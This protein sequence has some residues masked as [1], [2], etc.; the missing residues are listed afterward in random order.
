MEDATIKATGVGSWK[1][2]RSVLYKI[3]GRH[4]VGSLSGQGCERAITA[5]KEIQDILVS[6]VNKMGTEATSPT[7]LKGSVK[8]STKAKVQ[9]LVLFSKQ[10]WFPLRWMIC[11]SLQKKACSSPCQE[12]SR[13]KAFGVESVQASLANRFFTPR[14][15]FHTELSV[16]FFWLLLLLLLLLILP[17]QSFHESCDLMLLLLY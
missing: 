12:Y 3:K 13:K 4:A 8:L 7:C 16:E 17:V 15:C 2:V 11:N 14:C 10:R 9:F 6:E 1:T 5:R